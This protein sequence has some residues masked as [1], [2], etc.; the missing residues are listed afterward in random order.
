MWAVLG[1]I[2]DRSSLPS[3]RPKLNKKHLS[4]LKTSPEM[5]GRLR[6]SATFSS[7]DREIRFKCGS[8]AVCLLLW[9]FLPGTP[10]FAQDSSEIVPG[11]SLQSLKLVRDNVLGIP[12]EEQD[13]YYSLLDQARST[14]LVA[15]AKTFWN[16]RKKEHPELGNSSHPPFADLF[17]QPDAYRGHPVS[18]VGHLR[19]VIEY[20]AGKNDYG[21]ENLYESWIYPADSDANPIVVVSTALH[22]RILRGD[23]LS[24]YVGVSGYYFKLYGYNAQDT[25]RR[26]PMLLAH[27]VVLLPPRTDTHLIQKR[28]MF[29]GLCAALFTPIF[30]FIIYKGMKRRETS[31]TSSLPDELPPLDLNHDNS[32]EENPAP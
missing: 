29:F 25:T 13:A 30:L 9:G 16:V 7:L 2:E 12:S 23:D 28:V 21:I 26:A 32:N 11:A 31:L 4:S 1:E 18:Q 5:H 10:V 3:T 17:Q 27:E 20:P 6:K 15:D 8:L 24:Q 19:R 22:P 14:N